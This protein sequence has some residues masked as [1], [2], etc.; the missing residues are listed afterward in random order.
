MAGDSTHFKL[1]LVGD[2]DER[3]KLEKMVDVFGVQ[4][5]VDFLG[6]R[7][8]IPRLLHAAD[9]FLLTSITEGI[10]LTLIEAQAAGL[11]CV[12]TRVGGVPEVVIEGTTGLLAEKRNDRE[13][14]RHLRCLQ[15]D[16]FLRKQL[17]AAGQRHVRDVFDADVMY[18]RYRE[19]YHKMIHGS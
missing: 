17:G 13:L 7:D 18:A 15:H 5:H 19:I 9:V 10:P 4:T 1:L 3:S 16:A 2:G 14:A 11:P 8:D 12:A 6:T